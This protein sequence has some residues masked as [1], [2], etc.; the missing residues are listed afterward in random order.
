LP[1]GDSFVG[2]NADD[3]LPVKFHPAAIN[4]KEVE[5]GGSIHL[6]FN[7]LELGDLAL[8]LSVGPG[9]CDRCVDGSLVLMTPLAKG[10]MRFAMLDAAM[11][12]SLRELSCGSAWDTIA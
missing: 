11:S 3:D 5:L 2:S 12:P 7:E 8:G 10:V 1:I 4:M 6:T 9:R